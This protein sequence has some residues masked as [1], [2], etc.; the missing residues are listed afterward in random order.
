[1]KWQTAWLLLKDVLLTGTG[2]AVILS[3]VPSAHPSDVLIAAGLA[4]TAPTIG[5]HVRELLRGPTDGQSS[6]SAESPGSSPS[7]S[8]QGDSGD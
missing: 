6:E 7:S 1:M 2:I 8:S 3:Q 4:L 5:T